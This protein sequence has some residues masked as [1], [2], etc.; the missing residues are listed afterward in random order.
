MDDR[1]ESAACALEES[2]HVASS[3]LQGQ[4]S[5]RLHS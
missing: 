4:I 2:E 1:E 5:Y 3:S